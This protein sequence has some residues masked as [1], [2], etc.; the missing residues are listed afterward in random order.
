[1]R[2][3]LFPWVRR[4]LIVCITTAEYSF[5]RWGPLIFQFLPRRYITEIFPFRAG[6]ALGPSGILFSELIFVESPRNNGEAIRFI[7]PDSLTIW[8]ELLKRGIENT[9]L[10]D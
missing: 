10:S 4:C 8:K 3:W 5:N 7:H 2:V 6:F 9:R 1:M